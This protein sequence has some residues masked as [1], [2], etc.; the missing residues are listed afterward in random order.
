PV[1]LITGL[2]ISILALRR[3]DDRLVVYCAHDAEFSDAILREFERQ[4]GI[5]VSVRYD[6][7][8][9]K[10]LGLVNLL[11]SEKDHP[12]CDVFWNN[13]L[14][15]MVDLKNAGVLEPYRGTGFARIPDRYKDP[16]GFWVGFAARLRVFI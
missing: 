2:A 10:S 15:G 8:A 1:V 5:P 3:G 4:T 13:E 16:D 14:L 9:T 7:E 12:R 11:K 6:T